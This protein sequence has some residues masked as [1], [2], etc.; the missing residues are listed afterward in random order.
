VSVKGVSDAHVTGRTAPLG[1]WDRRVLPFDVWFDRVFPVVGDPQ[2]RTQ[3][4]TANC[5]RSPL[6]ILRAFV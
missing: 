4:R 1:D 6:L 2:E 3:L 5:C